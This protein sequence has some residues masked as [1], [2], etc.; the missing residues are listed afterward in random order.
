[1]SLLADKFQYWRLSPN[2]K[3][4]YYGDCGENETPT[5]EHLSNK[6]VVLDI[7]QLITGERCKH[8]KQSGRN[9]VRMLELKL[10]KHNRLFH[11]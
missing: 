3:A 11:K 2:H 4:F 1:M 5:L 6:V 8:V 9:R 7:K 10:L